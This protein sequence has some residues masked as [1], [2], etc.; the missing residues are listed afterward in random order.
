[1]EAEHVV[2]YGP[3]GR[4]NVG[5]TAG[6]SCRR[7]FAES[8][9]FPESIPGCG[10]EDGE[11]FRGLMQGGARPAADF[12][13]VVGRGTPT[14]WSGFWKQW[15]SRGKPIPY[16]DVHVA[17]RSLIGATV[18]RALAASRSLVRAM[19]ILPNVASAAE[20]A[21]ESP[22]RWGDFVGFWVL[23]NLKTLAIH[24]GAGQS[25]FRIWR[26]RALSRDSH[27]LRGP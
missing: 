20:R 21:R 9:K 8:V 1:L 11:F 26:D 5:W 4:A 16:V 2:S 6:F 23:C 13:I 24:R 15:T 18:R 27:G 22:R 14:T 19:L 3:T 17:H 10:G 25:L 12:E 7:R